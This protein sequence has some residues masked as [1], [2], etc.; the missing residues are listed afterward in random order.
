MM[1]FGR[2]LLQRKVVDMD[3]DLRGTLRNLGLKV[4]VV[5]AARSEWRVRDLVSD[6]PLIAAI[7]VSDAQAR[8]A[9]REQLDVLHRKPLELCATIRSADGS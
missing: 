2:R 8:A 7:I 4:G 3:N 6:D 5:G 9:I 1:G